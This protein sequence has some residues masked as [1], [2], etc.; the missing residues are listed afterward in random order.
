M[1][2]TL[3]FHLFPFRTEKLSPIVPMVL[4]NSGRV[5]SCHFKKRAG[6]IAKAVTPASHLLEGEG[7][8]A[9]SP[10]SCFRPP[11]IPHQTS[12]TPLHTTTCPS[13]CHA[14]YLPVL[15]LAPPDLL[16]HLE[17]S[18]RI[19]TKASPTYPTPP[20][21][22]MSMLALHSSPCQPIGRKR[23][24][25]RLLLL[26]ILAHGFYAGNSPTSVS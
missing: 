20:F 5:G 4:R 18:H 17:P 19:R 9:T 24:L 14:S 15:T 10:S 25:K 8:V 11:A 21:L 16:P 12:P 2:I 26:C 3:G 13:P 22:S 7:A 23:K 1:V 6:V